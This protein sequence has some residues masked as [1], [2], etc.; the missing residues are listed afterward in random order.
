MEIRDVSEK[1][2]TTVSD[3]EGKLRPA[4]QSLRLP[5]GPAGAHPSGFLRAP[6]EITA[7]AFKPALW[8]EP[9][10]LSAPEGLNASRCTACLWAVGRGRAWAGSHGQLLPV[11]FR[12]PPTPS[13]RGSGL[14]K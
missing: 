7:G 11:T 3:L 4:P 12:S 6:G 1:E 8:R 9:S 13:S 5:L 2:K 14:A 10:P